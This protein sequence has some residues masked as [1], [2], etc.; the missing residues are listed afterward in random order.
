MD[1]EE[2]LNQMKMPIKAEEVFL[3]KIVMPN[4]ENPGEIL[5]SRHIL[6]R[7]SLTNGKEDLLYN[8]ILAHYFS[9]PQDK[10]YDYIKWEYIINLHELLKFFGFNSNLYGQDIQNM[11]ATV[12]NGNFVKKYCNYFGY[13][14]NP[15]VIFKNGKCHYAKKQKSS[16]ALYRRF[17]NNNLSL[18]FP[19]LFDLNPSNSFEPFREEGP[20]KARKLL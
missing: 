11:L 17:E 2:L 7:D 19:Y 5:N 14:Y 20:I 9:H 8:T 15:Q 6:F 4:P 12:L 10:D 1:L 13:I 16:I 18:Y 3:S